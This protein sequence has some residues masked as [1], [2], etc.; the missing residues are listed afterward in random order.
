MIFLI[1]LLLLLAGL[2]AF[3]LKRRP[4]GIFLSTWVIGEIFLIGSG[5]IPAA[6][7]KNLQIYPIIKTIQWGSQNTIILLG[8]GITP[9]QGNQIGSTL[10]GISRVQ[11]GARLYFDCKKQVLR[12]E[13]L[14][15]GGDPLHLGISEAETMQKDLIR[16]GVPDSSI[17]LESKSN[18]TYQNA[19]FSSALLQERKTGTLVL[20]TSGGH[21]R[22][23]LLYFS[24]FGISAIPA[25]SDHIN[26]NQSW[27]PLSY[28]F[29]LTD[30]A[31]HEFLGILRLRLTQRTQ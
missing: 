27:M 13:I 23:A 16:L 14:V 10:F 19:E 26:A 28:N 7:L 2:G 9:W 29:F 30:L 4:V 21:M 31:V 15:S 20:V 6:L 12:C 8:G 17:F 24:H 18:N 3:V 11:E 5:L 25:P 22:R 1:F